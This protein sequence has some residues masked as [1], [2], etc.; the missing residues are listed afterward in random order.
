MAVVVVDLA[1]T[2]LAFCI[3]LL[4]WLPLAYFC[5]CNKFRLYINT[6]TAMVV[7][8]AIC[9][10]TYIADVVM[11]AVCIFLLLLWLPFVCN[12]SCYGC[13]LYIAVVVMAAFLYI[14][15]VVE[16]LYI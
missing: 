9:R 15:A 10:P 5:C 7:M 8:A 13:R 1:V 16:V 12:C 11:V 4:L 14:A 3:L 6:V 2:V